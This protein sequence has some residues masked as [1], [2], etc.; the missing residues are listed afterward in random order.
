[1][2]AVHGRQCPPLPLPYPSLKVRPPSHCLEL[3][4]GQ[5][6]SVCMK[7]LTARLLEGGLGPFGDLLRV[8]V[9]LLGESS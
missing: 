2:R 6:Q 4:A 1:M 3:L 5:K 7:S 8:L 9:L